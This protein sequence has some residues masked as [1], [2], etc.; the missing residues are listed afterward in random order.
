MAANQILISPHQSLEAM[1]NILSITILA[2]TAALAVAE[3]KPLA[4]RLEELPGNVVEK[5]REIARDAKDAVVDT[6]RRVGTTARA[7]WIKSRGYLSEDPT[8][9]RVGAEQKL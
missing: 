3:D 9:F 1:K 4:N 7:M 8:V 2:V 6:T 5:T